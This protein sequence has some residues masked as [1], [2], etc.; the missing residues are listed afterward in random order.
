MFNQVFALFICLCLSET[1]QWTVKSNDAL[2]LEGAAAACFNSFI[3]IIGGKKNDTYN[4]HFYR[5][6]TSFSN[7]A[8]LDLPDGYDSSSYSTLTAVKDGLLLIGGE[9]NGTALSSVYLFNGTG[10][11]TTTRELP[12]SVTLQKHCAAAHSTGEYVLIYG[13]L[14]NKSIESNTIYICRQGLFL[15]F[16]FLYPF[17][18]F[19]VFSLGNDYKPEKLSMNSVLAY[20]PSISAQ[21][22][23]WFLFFCL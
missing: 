12:D 6:D 11:D 9:Y 19:T 23:F 10:W 7:I 8:E 16:N 17:V 5:T 22:T 13:G 15:V 20:P 18:F 3:Y 1:G 4:T 14:N 2:A 21:L